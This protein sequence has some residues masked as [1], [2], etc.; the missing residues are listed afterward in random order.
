M[1]H[2]WLQAFHAVAREG[3]FTAA[4]R[5]LN[6]GQPTI[7][8]HVKALE[9][10]FGVELFDRHGRTVKLTPLG[11]SLLKITQGLYG[12]EEEA[13]KLLRSAQQLEAGELRV[14]AIGPFDIMELLQH[15]RDQH[16]KVSLN[17]NLGKKADVLTDL[18]EFETD[19]G[20]LAEPATDT[21]F[22]QLFYNR[23]EVLVIVNNEHP[24][25]RRKRIRIRELMDQ[26]MVLRTKGSTTRSAFEKAIEEAGVEVQSVMEINNREAVREAVVRG[27][28]IGVVSQSEFIPGERLRA[29]R[30][31]DTRMQVDAH[32]ACLVERLDRPLI[33]AFFAIAENLIKN[34]ARKV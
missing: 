15:F 11:R 16:P 30:I 5:S 29:L 25:A 28:G 34:R 20:I 27:L 23:Y 3:G 6:L 12:H 13:V 21:R 33:G 7:S 22:H 26:P 2:K 9:Q 4:A 32:V 19:V 10:Q 24:W 31:T 14:G 17:V 18:L 8:I 1:Y